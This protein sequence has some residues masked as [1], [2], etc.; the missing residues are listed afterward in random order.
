MIRL[1]PQQQIAADAPGNTLVVAGAGAGKTGTLVERCTR[2]LLRSED[3]VS[4]SKV[5]VVTFTEAAAAEVRDRIRKGLDEEVKSDPENL[6][7]QEQI[8]GLD[9]AHISTLHSFCLRLIRENFYELD[10]DPAVA[11]IPAEHAEMLFSSTFDELLHEHLAGTDPVSLALKDVLRTHFRGWDQLLRDLI[12]KLHHFTQTRPD[13]EGW[14]Q[15]QVTALSSADCHQWRAWYAETITRWTQWWL[16][17]LESLPVENENA[18]ECVAIFKK[19][20]KSGAANFLKTIL[21]RKECWPK[22]KKGA[23]SKPFGKFFDEAAF[24]ESLADPKALQQDWDWAREPLRV[25]LEFARE[26]TARYTLAKRER[27][28]VD[29]H[30]LEQ[31]ALHLLWDQAAKTPSALAQSWQNRFEAVFV[32]EYQDINAAQDLIVSAVSRHQPPGNRFLVGD[33]K[34]S[35][36][37]FRQANPSIFRSYLSESNWVTAHLS[38]NFRSHE[39]ILEFINPLFAWLMLERV[40]G[41]AYDETARL[42]F[43]GREQRSALTLAPGQHLPVELHIFVENKTGSDDPTET[44]NSEAEELERAEKEAR[45]VARR[46]R[47]LHDQKFE[48][49][50]QKEKI[51]RP[52]EWRD[53]VV[54]LRAASGKL[55]VYAKAFEAIGVPLQTKRDGFFSTME[56]L[57]LLNVLNILDNPL[58]DIPLVAALRSPLFGLTAND[59]ALVRIQSRT[60][61]ESLP[62]WEALKQFL[63]QKKDSPVRQK[64]ERFMA[65]YLRWRN[66]RDCSSLA[67]RLETILSESGYAEW[68][69]SQPRGR[70]RHA[71]VQQLLNVARQFESSRG[72]SLYL[73]LRHIKDLQNTAGDIEPASLSDENAVRLMTV[74]QSKGLE[75]PVVAV[76]DLGKKFNR[77]S[78]SSSI[79]FHDTYGICS[80]I[81][82]PGNGRQYP[83][84]PHW[85]ASRD[86]R[87]SATGEEMRVLYVA[88]TRA[89]NLLLL[90]GSTTGKS[91][92][93]HWP[94]NAVEMPFPQQLV[95]MQSWLDW[96]GTFGAHRWPDWLEGEAGRNLPFKLELHREVPQQERALQESVPSWSP[97]EIAALHA[98]YAFSYTHE[99]AT[100]EPA[101]GTVSLLRK[102]AAE[103]N[104]ES[105][106]IARRFRP[107]SSSAEARDRGVATHSFLQNLD[108]STQTDPA[109][110]FAHAQQLM[111]DGFL[112]RADLDRIDFAAISAFWTS[113]FGRE[114]L[115]QP[116]NVR[117]E[118]PFTFKAAGHELAGLGLPHL[119]PLPPDE[120]VLIQGVADLVVLA[121]EEIWL[122]D[123]KTDNITAHEVNARTADYKPQIA[124]YALALERIYNRRVTRRGLYYLTPGIFA[125]L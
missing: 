96:L 84:L 79:L 2:L 118:F 13:P 109:G 53:M 29:F 26:F 5:L 71:N 1:T 10:L 42:R 113:A 27:G 46:L 43:G 22:N 67:D 115:A 74:H 51:T 83:S 34:Q 25:I 44:E 107:P 41:V 119:L 112:E 125:W 87:L 76:A 3:P 47:K 35:I 82:P 59:L 108:L 121:G 97:G 11:V 95:R 55:E 18:R 28:V 38:E 93:E 48:I 60:H 123:F 15:S 37:A 89:E 16:P 103:L 106:D 94:N 69:L 62:F 39:G 85:V 4:V 77:S 73:F 78:Q 14:F 65:C 31:H 56:V 92:T 12:R 7:F 30:D 110:L 24:L 116:E 32:D 75:F 6:W 122:L 9:A 20:S 101:K 80:M 70:Q 105:A 124:L 91:L 63:E 102:R 72:E 86:E 61:S 45:L 98:R 117:R 49:F 64:I 57:D 40:G 17:Y 104:E 52:V 114:I 88:L 99:I 120:F 66:P 50:H 81:K 8:A 33:I 21:E 23:H 90:F 68:I 36:Y 111:K 58:Q 100:N 54:L 19:A